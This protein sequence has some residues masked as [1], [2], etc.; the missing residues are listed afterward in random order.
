M[1]RS[2]GY[3]LVAVIA[4]GLMFTVVARA[5]PHVDAFNLTAARYLLGGL[6]LL[7]LL[8]AREG[9]AALRTGGR[10]IELVVLGAVGFAGF[11]LLANLALSRTAPQNAAL[12]VALTPLLTVLIRWVRDG[13]RPRPSTVALVAVALAGVLMVITKGHLSGLSAFGSGDLLM[14]GGVL[15]WALYTHGSSRFPEFSPLRYASLT[16]GTGTATILL[17]TA[18]ADAFG[19]QRLPSTGDLGRVW[20]EL[21]YLVFIGAVIAMLA[22]NTGVRRLGAPNTALFMNLVPVIALVVAIVQGYRPGPAEVVGIAVTV[23]AIATAN[24]LGRRPVARTAVREPQ[25]A[26]QQLGTRSEEPLSVG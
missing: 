5:L 18:V 15:G 8:A 4:W 1:S 12:M 7:G 24:L 17:A 25:P 3:P 26:A 23:G 19:W 20:P 2:A 16:A 13:V 6:I 9:R 10:T 11:N 14:L 21:A 22:W